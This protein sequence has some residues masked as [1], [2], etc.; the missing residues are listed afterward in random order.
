VHLASIHLDRGD[1]A[2]AHRLL[3]HIPGH[4]ETDG[5]P[6]DPATRESLAAL[7]KQLRAASPNPGRR[8]K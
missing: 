6:N 1:T 2:E 5:S 3:A 4:H 8:P 7:Y